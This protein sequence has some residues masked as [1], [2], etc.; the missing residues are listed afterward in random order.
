M[1][2]LR[3]RSWIL[4]GWSPL[5]LELTYRALAHLG[6]FEERFMY[7]WP[8]VCVCGGW[9]GVCVCLQVPVCIHTKSR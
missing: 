8:G 2:S 5:F 9:V 3:V 6:I 1:P 7:T 4:P